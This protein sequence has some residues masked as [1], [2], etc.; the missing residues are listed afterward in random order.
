MEHPEVKNMTFW[1]APLTL[2][3][4][5]SI[6]TIKYRTFSIRSVKDSLFF[7][8]LIDDVAQVLD[9]YLLVHYPVCRTM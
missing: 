7:A 6:K 1:T 2:Y 9:P 3:K 8:L 5:D 4:V